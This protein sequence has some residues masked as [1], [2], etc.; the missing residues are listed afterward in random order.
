MS[1]IASGYDS[2]KIKVNEKEFAEFIQL[3]Q[4]HLIKN[5]TLLKKFHQR[6]TTD[7]HNS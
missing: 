2:L 4:Y 5:F 3:S 7:K 1:E 6:Q